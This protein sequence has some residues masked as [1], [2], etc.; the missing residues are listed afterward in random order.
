[1][2]ND[3]TFQFVRTQK[4]TTKAKTKK[5]WELSSVIRGLNSMTGFYYSSLIIPDKHVEK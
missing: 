2:I 5:M 1:M 4:K 3:N